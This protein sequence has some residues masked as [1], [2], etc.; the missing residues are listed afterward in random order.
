MLWW[1][2]KNNNILTLLGKI[3]KNIIINDKIMSGEHVENVSYHLLLPVW[4]SE[5]KV[6][7][8][9]ITELKNHIKKC[10]AL[11]LTAKNPFNKKLVF[12]DETKNT[13]IELCGEPL[14]TMTRLCKKRTL[15][16]IS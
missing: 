5:N 15:E 14:K 7:V 1:G 3:P 10:E 6:H 8:F 9:H 2:N 13:V 11:G 16:E 12:S 4:C